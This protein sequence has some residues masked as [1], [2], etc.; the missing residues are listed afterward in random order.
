MMRPAS[1]DGV[2]AVSERILQ[3]ALCAA[4]LFMAAGCSEQVTSSLGCPELCTDQTATV[5]DTVLAGAIVL[6]ST[7]VGFPLRGETRELSL[8]ARGDTADVRIIARFD[9]LPQRYVPA[10]PQAD[11]LIR[12]VDSASLIFRIDT[13]FAK[14]TIPVTIEAFDVDTTVTTDADTMPATLLPLFRADRLLGSKTYQVA[15]LKDTVR[16]PLDTAALRAKIMRNQRLRIGLRLSGSKSVTLRVTGTTFLP[17]VRF[18]VSPDTTVRP[19]TVYLRSR[20][21]SDAAIANSLLF[22]SLIAKGALPPPPSSVLALGGL[23]GA[24]TYMRFDIPGIVLDSV[25]VIRA[26][27]LLTQL[28]S[29]STGGD[30]DTLTVYAQAVTAGPAVTDVFTASQFLSPLGVFRVDT[31]RLIP[32]TSGLRSVEVVN[33]VRAWRLVGS[34]NAM[35]AL[36]LRV[37]EEGSSPGELNF[38]ST[39]GPAASRPRLRITYV[40]RRG[41]G[42][43]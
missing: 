34:T 10:A 40:P 11:S 6:D 21:P 16:L 17:R 12:K 18:R 32:S 30:R 26:S 9:T 14:P 3:G 25:Q 5:K 15:D 36:V 7:L 13:L 4:L 35:R 42:I 33:L 22:Y 23:A 39:E 24:R 1:T 41:F 20:T 27:L 28:R 8:V 37:P 29:R 31:L 2:Y 43:P 19:D 38:S